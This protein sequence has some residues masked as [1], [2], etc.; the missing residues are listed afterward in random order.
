MSRKEE[1]KCPQSPIRLSIIKGRRKAI[2]GKK[3][4]GD[5]VKLSI[6]LG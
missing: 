6:I 3:K 4:N 1:E 5:D 2:R